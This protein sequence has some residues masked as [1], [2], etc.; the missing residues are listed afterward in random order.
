MTLWILCVNLNRYDPARCVPITA[1]IT[2]EECS[3]ELV[4]W[5]H[6]AFAWEVRSQFTE[7]VSFSWC[8]PESYIN[9]R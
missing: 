9:D 3:R 6:R 4:D 8:V 1:P 5:Q 7:P 2:Y